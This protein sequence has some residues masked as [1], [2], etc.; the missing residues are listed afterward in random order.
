MMLQSL[1]VNAM[2]LNENFNNM[3]LFYDDNIEAP[4]D[5]KA[6]LSE[7]TEKLEEIIERL[8]RLEKMGVPKLSTS[9]VEKPLM[10][11]SVQPSAIAGLYPPSNVVPKNSMLG[12]IQSVLASQSMANS[13]GAPAGD[14]VTDVCSLPS[15]AY[16]D[17]I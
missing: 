6:D 11:E 9:V 16:D 17:I 4:E 2:R 14:V 12:E 8:D 7:I 15:S 5:P 1:E 13:S 10:T 3:P